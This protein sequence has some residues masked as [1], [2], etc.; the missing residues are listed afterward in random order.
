MYVRLKE[1]GYTDSDVRGAMISDASKADSKTRQAMYG[2]WSKAAEK[3][4]AGDKAKFDEYVKRY[5][6][7]AEKRKKE[8]KGGKSR[9][10]GF[11]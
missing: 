6:D 10:F 5:K 3:A 8:Q 7:K 9:R 4:K 11:W 2:N 1:K